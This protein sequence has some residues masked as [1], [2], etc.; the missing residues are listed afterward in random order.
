MALLY[1]SIHLIGSW[2]LP[3]LGLSRLGINGH[4]VTVIH[5]E[6]ILDSEYG[7]STKLDVLVGDTSNKRK[8]ENVVPQS[9]NPAQM[10]K[11]RPNTMET[12]CHSHSKSSGADFEWTFSGRSVQRG[13]RD[14]LDFLRNT[15]WGVGVAIPGDGSENV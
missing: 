7:F 10:R 5:L 2:L 3:A 11:V 9:R 15:D 6:L 1:S 8:A 12:E 4:W 13:R 14:S